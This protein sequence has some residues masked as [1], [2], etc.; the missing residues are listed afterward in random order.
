MDFSPHCQPSCPSHD[1]NAK[2]PAMTGTGL[3]TTTLLLQLVGP[4][5]TPPSI[6]REAAT[7]LPHWWGTFCLQRHLVFTCRAVDYCW[8]QYLQQTCLTTQPVYPYCA[9]T[10]HA[11][12]PAP[13]PHALA[14][15]GPK[16]GGRTILGGQDPHPT[17]LTLPQALLSP[18]GQ[19][20]VPSFFPPTPPAPGQGQDTAPPPYPSPT[21]TCPTLTQDRTWR[22]PFPTCPTQVVPCYLPGRLLLLCHSM[23]A[24]PHLIS[25]PSP[26]D[27][28]PSPTCLPPPHRAV[29]TTQRPPCWDYLPPIPAMPPPPGKCR[30][31]GV[32]SCRK[33]RLVG[34]DRQPNP[35]QPQ[36][37]LGRRSS[38]TNIFPDPCNL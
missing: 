12:L 28:L 5:A 20:M 26:W 10:A 30:R 3:P 18:G 37:T 33:E 11:K 34:T 25:G 32:A 7:V 31:D 8:T 16:A 35:S 15:P 6:G 22:P 23:P 21:P 1:P 36:D 17:P 13:I 38:G 4:Q 19:H 2:T 14:F 27:P 29:E 24:L 9:T